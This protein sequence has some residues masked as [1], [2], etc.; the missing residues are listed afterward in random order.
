MDQA[1]IA[2][3][4]SE[5]DR[6]WFAR[7]HLDIAEREERS[8]MVHAHHEGPL[9][10]QR[11]FYPEQDGC[12]H[13][14][15]LHPPG[16]LVIGDELQIS[17]KLQQNAK[18]LLTTPSAAKV[19]SAGSAKDTLSQGQTLKFSVAEGGCLEW[20]PQETILF[21]GARAHLHT[22]IDLEKNARFFAWDMLGLG[23][24][25]SGEKFDHG[26]CCQT[27]EIFRDHTLV[28]RERNK[29]IGGGSLQKAN[30]GLRGHHASATL[31][32]TL[33]PESECIDQL[34]VELDRQ[35]KTGLWGL[36]QKEDIFI[37]RYLGDSIRHCRNGFERI[38]RVTRKLLNNKSA[39][40]PRIWHT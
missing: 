32:A 17:A 38:W 24:I 15:L 13:V 22:R 4:S 28:F 33:E 12:C 3:D 19:Y 36:S 37:A 10:V 34:Y 11:P 6:H 20:L 21:A 1:T 25:A 39:V 2:L 7:L 27:I 23:R 35:E 30:C 5:T 14:Y 40:I 16:G 26:A 18:A 29:I 8:V 31:V 9:R